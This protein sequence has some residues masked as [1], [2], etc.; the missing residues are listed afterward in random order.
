[1]QIVSDSNRVLQ[2]VYNLLNEDSYTLVIKIPMN[3][4]AKK[5]NM[6][7]KHLNLCIH[8]LIECG[9]LKGDFCYSDNEKDNKE[10]FILPAAIDKI[11]SVSI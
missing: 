10:V 8:Y 11:E 4:T 3:D 5:L 7:M 2:E 6:S 9:Y 1:M